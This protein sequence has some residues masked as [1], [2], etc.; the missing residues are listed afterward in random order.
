MPYSI[1][2]KKNEEKRIFAGHP[3]VYANEVSRIDGKDK[4]GS[5]ATVFDYSGRYLGKGFIN[6]LSKILVR[7]FIRDD[8]E[9]SED[10]FKERILYADSYR[11]VL[12]LGEAHTGWFSENH[13]NLPGLVIDK[14]EDVYSLQFL[15]LGMD[16]YKDVIVKILIELFSHACIYERSDLSV[17][18]KRRPFA[19]KGLLYGE[20]KSRSKFLKTVLRCWL[21]SRMDK[22]LVIFRSKTKQTSDKAIFGRK[23]CP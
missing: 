13:D 2:L 18:E 8:K 20:L 12:D 5:L 16:N 7:I 17:R 3:W 23:K 21:M 14:Y 19:T 22:K 1:Y 9:V 15:T 10:L 6:H 11:K 4:N